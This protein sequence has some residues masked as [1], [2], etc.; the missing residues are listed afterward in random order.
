[1]YETFASLPQILKSFA[2]NQMCKSCKNDFFYN[3]FG[4]WCFFC[5]SDL[6]IAD[7]LI[8]REGILIEE[9]EKIPKKIK[10]LAKFLCFKYL[11]EFRNMPKEHLLKFKSIGNKSVNK[12]EK[13]MKERWGEITK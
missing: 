8:T 13:V 4:K 7:N 6:S 1:M 9:C 5:G 10:Q 12:L 3:P 2:A 11:H